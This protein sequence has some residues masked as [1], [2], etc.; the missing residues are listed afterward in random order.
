M[1]SR[2]IKPMIASVAVGST[3]AN[4]MASAANPHYDK[5]VI[6]R[7]VGHSA[8]QHHRHVVHRY[9]RNGGPGSPRIWTDAIARD[10]VGHEIA[11]NRETVDEA[12]DVPTSTCSNNMRDV[13]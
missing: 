4:A 9:V 2:I 11:P 7:A 1:T 10:S 5:L 6:E 12:C 13:N 3:T 8:T